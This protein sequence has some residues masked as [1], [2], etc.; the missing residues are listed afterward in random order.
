VVGSEPEV[1]RNFTWAVLMMEDDNLRNLGG[2]TRWNS[3][4]LKH[5]HQLFLPSFYAASQLLL[6]SFWISLR[7]E[8]GVY[9]TLA[10]KICV[11]LLKPPKNPVSI[12]QH[13]LSN[14]PTH[15]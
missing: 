15:S 14:S 3:Q 12:A 7:L 8:I 9:I 5:T 10:S 4:F 11:N 2:V 6:R 1:A 13:F